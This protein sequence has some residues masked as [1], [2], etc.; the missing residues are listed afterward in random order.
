MNP[1]NRA[2]AVRRYGACSSYAERCQLAAQYGL[3]LRQLHALW[4][5]FCTR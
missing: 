5:A 2:Q 4:I 3:T 1:H